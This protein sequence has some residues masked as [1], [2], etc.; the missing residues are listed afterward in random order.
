MSIEKLGS[1]KG[2]KNFKSYDVY[3]DP[4]S[5]ETYVDCGGRKAIGKAKSPSNAMNMADAYVRA[6]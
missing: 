3:W 6:K 5:G 2:S 4:H 1:V